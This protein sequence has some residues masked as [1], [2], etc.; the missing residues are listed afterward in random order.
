[1]E[2]ASSG[3]PVLTTNVDGCLPFSEKIWVCSAD[4]FDPFDLKLDGW[5][6][7]VQENIDEYDDVFGELHDRGEL[8]II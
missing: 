1:M 4:K 3:L 2:Y 5:S 6:E 7:A 8:Y